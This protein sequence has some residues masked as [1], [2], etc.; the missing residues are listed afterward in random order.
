MKNTDKVYYVYAHVNKINDKVYVGMSRQDNPNDRWKNGRGYE[1]NFHFNNAIKKYGWDNFDHIILASGLTEV[2]ASDLEAHIIKKFELTN[3]E[4]GY[5][6][7]D[8]GYNNRGLSG[9]RN[10]FYKK[11]PIKAIEASV[12]SRIGKRLSEE[13]KEKIRQGNIKAGRNENSI[14]ALLDY[15]RSKIPHPSG[16]QNKKS[17][18]VKCIENGIVYESQRIAEMELN[19][20]RGSVYQAIKNNIRAKG[21]HFIRV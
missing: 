20:P 21:Y 19:L 6:S 7:A 14:K 16:A 2:E 17:T 1:Y 15:D 11:P 18:A 3:A 10:P 5:N 8:G 4:N 12:R 9:E 13:H